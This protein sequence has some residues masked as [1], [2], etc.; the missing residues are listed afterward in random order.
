[1]SQIQEIKERVDLVEIVGERVKLQRSGKNYR[2]LCPFHSEKSPSFFVSPDLQTFKCFGCGKQGD[3]FTFLEEYERLTFREGLELL[4]KKVGIE[5]INDTFDPQEQMRQRVLAALDAAQKYFAYLLNEHKVGEAGRAYLKNRQTTASTIKNFGLGFAADGWDHLTTYLTKKKKFTTE[6]L[7]AAGLV[8]EGKNNRVYD[9]FRNRVMFPLHDHRGR[10]VGFS[11]RTLAA[12]VK[13]AKY[14]NSPETMV[15]H[16]RNLL[17]GYTQNLNAIRE[18]EAAIV[19]EGEFDV[20][21]S[22]QAHVKN[23]VA[24]K[25]S[26]LATEQ[27]RLLSRVA[28]TIYLSLDADSAG[29]EATKRAIE[30]VQG[31]EIA[32]RVIPVAG[33]K[34]PDDL[35]RQNPAQWRELVKQHQAAFDYLLVQVSKQHDLKSAAGQRAVS[36]EL[37]GLVLKVEHPVE[38]NFYLQKLGETLSTPVHVL[39][40]QLNRLQRKQEISTGKRARYASHGQSAQAGNQ[41]AKSLNDSPNT[42]NNSDQEETATPTDKLEET[43]WQLAWQHPDPN[44]TVQELTKLNFTDPL[45]TKLQNELQKFLKNHKQ[46]AMSDFAKSIPGELTD[47]VTRL[48]V[49]NKDFPEDQIAKIWQDTLGQIQIRQYRQRLQEISQKLKEFDQLETLSQE[50][51]TQQ[52]T[53]FA[54]HMKLTKSLQ[55]QIDQV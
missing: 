30:A 43:I 53:L 4:A 41:S 7:I 15:Y 38:R 35:A 29:I 10:V 51:E 50:Q 42:N 49:I 54:E 31:F 52:Q 40:D 45:L 47:I 55:N 44:Q 18:K 16:K 28:K 19:V 21:S 46:F 13:E 2:G 22:M 24:V 32:L 34:D 9:R 17:F 14:I 48:Y 23:V 1:M 25:G 26:A 27:I 8:I 6:E 33:G 3:V 36:D 5:L 12:D 39:E 37:L 20:L 11:G